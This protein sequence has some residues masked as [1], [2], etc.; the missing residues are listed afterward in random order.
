MKVQQQM[1]GREDDNFCMSREERL[2]A[3]HNSNLLAHLHN[4]SGDLIPSPHGLL[5]TTDR[6]M[7]GGN[8]QGLVIVCG[9]SHTYSAIQCAWES[10]TV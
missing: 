1:D 7:T 5:I 6:R 3:S 4:Q 10:D 8:P 9:P 2:L